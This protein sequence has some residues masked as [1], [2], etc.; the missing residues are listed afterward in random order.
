VVEVVFPTGAEVDRDGDGLIDVELAWQDSGGAI[1]LDAITVRTSRGLNGPAGPETNLLDAWTVTRRDSS[2]LVFHETIENLLHPGANSLTVTVPD[3]AGN[4]ATRVLSFSAPAGAYHKTLSIGVPGLVYDIILCP[5]DDFAYVTVG[6]SMAVIDLETTEIVAADT[7][8]GTAGIRSLCVAGDPLIYVTSGDFIKLFNRSTQT[9]AGELPSGT[10]T[11]GIA[12]SRADPNV[13]YVGKTGSGDV[14]V[15][16]RTVGEQIRTIGLPPSTSQDEFVGDLAVLP[17]DEK[18]Y[19]PRH[20][21]G[22]VIV[23]DPVTGSVLKWL[24]FVSG[25][26][27]GVVYHMDLSSDDTRLYMALG[28]GAPA[29]LWEIDTTTDETRR[30]MDFPDDTPIDVALSPAGERA[31]LTTQNSAWTPD[32]A[33]DNYLID[34]TDWAVLAS[35]PRPRPAGETRYDLAAVWH[36]NGRLILAA[37]DGDIDVYLSRE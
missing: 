21:E 9:W 29:G 15:I 20:D 16:D 33:S 28:R 22:G 24:D 3:T 23:A 37:H 34:I 10:V 30:V 4:V 26:S 35:F 31:F 5:D 36:P 1:D 17:G 32:V 25:A 7:R 12:P 18:I 13:F 2:G 11:A 8:T 27:N 19:V 14:A 6:A